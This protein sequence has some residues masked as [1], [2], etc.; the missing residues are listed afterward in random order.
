MV[1]PA[2]N[3]AATP[4]CS[5]AEGRKALPRPMNSTKPTM[6]I[7]KAKDDP[8]GLLALSERGHAA[9]AIDLRSHH[10]EQQGEKHK[11]GPG[12]LAVE[13]VGDE[14]RIDPIEDD[15]QCNPA[16]PARHKSTTGKEEKENQEAGL[17]KDIQGADQ[18][19]PG[20]RK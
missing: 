4:D 19:K 9:I 1:V 5:S 15:K 16:R 17:S 10:R 18:H 7:E 3:V 11:I 8:P 12:A 2:T 20:R 6:P 14:D 13:A